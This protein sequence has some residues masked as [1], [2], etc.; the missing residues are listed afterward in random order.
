MQAFTNQNKMGNLE[1]F[2][3]FF[4]LQS[5]CNVKYIFNLWN[6]RVDVTNP[7][8]KERKHIIMGKIKFEQK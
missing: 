2:A 1:H 6:L 8:N 5:L 7:T 4:L 3:K